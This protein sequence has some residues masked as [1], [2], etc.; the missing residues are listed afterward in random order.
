MVDPQALESLSTAP[1]RCP[2]SASRTWSSASSCSDRSRLSNDL[3]RRLVT[4]LADAPQF[5]QLNTLL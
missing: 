4:R 2:Y 5:G 3:V 1:E